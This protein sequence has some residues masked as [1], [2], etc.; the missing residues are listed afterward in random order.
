[1]FVGDNISLTASIN[2]SDAS[3]KEVIWGTS[4]D[5]IATIDKKG[6]LKALKEGK[7]DVTVKTIDGNKTSFITLNIK[8]KESNTKIV[9]NK[10]NISLK[11]SQS[12]TIS[13]KVTNNKKV[14][15]TSSDPKVATVDSNGKVVARKSGVAT[16]IVTS[17]DKKATA[18]V[19][20][21]VENSE[22]TKNIT[23]ITS[24]ILNKSSIQLNKGNTYK[25]GVSIKPVDATNKVLKYTSSDESIA[26]V[27]N[28][29]MIKG[30]GLGTA[31]I[32]VSATDDSGK[33]ATIEV[34]V[35]PSTKIINITNQKYNT[36]IKNIENYLGTKNSKHM[37]NFAIQNIGKSDEIIYL[38][39]V[40]SGS[41]KASSINSYQ[42]DSLSRTIVIRIPKDELKTKTNNRTIMWMKKSGHGQSFDIESN[43]TMWINAFALEPSYSE[44]TWWGIHSGIMRIN[45]KSNNENSNFSSLESFKIKDSQGNIY[46]SPEVS[47]DEE[48]DLLALRSGSKVFVYKLSDA[49]KGK[50]KMLYSFK[51]LSNGI[52]KQGQDIS[53]GFYYVLYGKKGGPMSIIAYNM[54]GEVAYTKKFYIKNASQAQSQNEEAEGLKIY[55]SKIYIGHTHKLKNGNIFDIGVFK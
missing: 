20:V 19:S 27:D 1:M 38:S 24:M 49:K 14:I 5:T 8:N 13:A 15:W 30:L 35:T 43:G 52:Y 54:L 50:L 33:F 34:V 23:K 29:G 11:V 16:I 42:K 40:K 10:T 48:N 37:Q 7:V 17:E 12:E 41:I 2:P 22:Q 44:G 6:N 46:T 28:Q 26:T 31:T 32:K 21:K 3:N 36:Y 55:N 53:G 18:S 4:D 39:G 51:V 47:L 9:L 25:I 45:F